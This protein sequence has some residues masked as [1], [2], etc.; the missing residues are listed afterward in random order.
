ME[1]LQERRMVEDKLSVYRHMF[2]NNVPYPIPKYFDTVDRVRSRVNSHV[3]GRACER[4]TSDKQAAQN[5]DLFISAP[6]S[7]PQP[8][9][10]CPCCIPTPPYFLKPTQHCAPTYSI[11]GLF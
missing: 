9:A 10:P 4:G 5:S 11:L 6:H 3:G 7:T 8:P 1:L 2:A